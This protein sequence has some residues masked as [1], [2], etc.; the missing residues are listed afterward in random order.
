MGNSAPLMTLSA[1]LRY[2]ILI[3][4]GALCVVF[5]SLP[6]KHWWAL[7]AVLRLFFHMGSVVWYSREACGFL[8]LAYVIME[9]LVRDRHVS[10]VE[11]IVSCN[12]VIIILD[13]RFQSSC[14]HV[15]P[16]LTFSIP[17][18]LK[19]LFSRQ[20]YIAS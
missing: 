20:H 11:I 5:L 18:F 16:S 4:F 13:R 15:A 8:H 2:Q 19:S 12:I 1:G 9:A 7:R 14:T 17:G 3:H 6:R 10:V